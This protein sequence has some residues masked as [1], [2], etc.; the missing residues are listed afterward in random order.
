MAFADDLARHVEQIRGRIP[1]CDG[2]QAAKQALV[3]PL[4][5]LLGYDVFDPREVRPE[6]VAD[7]A[8]KKQGQFEKVDYAIYVG[9]QPA[10]FIECKPVG[11][12]LADH[13]GQLS[14]Y[15]NATPT[16][17]VAIITDGVTFRAFTDLRTAN[18]MDPQP[19]FSID[20][21]SLKPAEI[22]ALRRFR[23]ADFAVDEIVGLAEEM[24]FYNAMVEFLS[25]QLRE[26]SE[27]FVRFVAGE[28]QVAGRVTGRIVE[29][30]TPILRKA[31]QSTIVEHVARSF[32]ARPPATEPPVSS[33]PVAEAAP[34]AEPAH[35]MRDGVVTTAEETEIVEKVAAWIHEVEPDAKVVF[36]DSKSYFAMH[37]DNV[38]KWFLRGSA[39]RMPWSLNLR[40]VSPDD[41]RRLAPGVD[42]GEAG[43]EGGCRFS[44]PTIDDLGKVRAAIILAYQR[45]A[46]RTA[47]DASAEPAE[48]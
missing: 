29:R 20:L 37:Q 13:D 16:V 24:V 31:I 18:M 10:M 30:L 26:P 14:R 34:A 6:Y 45:E 35:K 2:E 33:T 4:L 40:H 47:E 23:K 41:A 1:H 11:A 7:F 46:Q 21:R 25:R 48:A 5:Q 8:V 12:E 42:V 17:R 36:R 38:R 19:W 22:D 28:I 27:P 32:E 3:V 39:D 15:F 9:E 43:F 44:L